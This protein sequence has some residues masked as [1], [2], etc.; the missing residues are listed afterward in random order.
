MAPAG[1]SPADVTIRPLLEADVAAA[2]AAAATAL[3][4]LYPEDVSPQ[5]QARRTESGIARIAHLQRTDPGGCWV[6]E[7]RARSSVPRSG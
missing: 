3:E 7:W 5:E 1:I 2:R 4:Q 6:A